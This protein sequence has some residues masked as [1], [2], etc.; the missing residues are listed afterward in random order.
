M[1]ICRD[2]VAMDYVLQN[3]PRYRDL[4]LEKDED[5]EWV[6]F[7]LM[8]QRTEEDLK[9]LREIVPGMGTVT[10]AVITAGIPCIN[11]H[12]YRPIRGGVEVRSRY[13]FGYTIV[14]KRPVRVLEGPQIIDK[15][16]IALLQHNM[17]EYPHLAR[18]LPS[19]Y[20][21]ESHKPVDAY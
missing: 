6:S 7:S 3:D 19:L 10:A 2:W 11:L 15:V 8:P 12:Y 9:R 5:G 21:E 17:L 4:L 14:D 18:F 1:K 13:W 20:A 16:L